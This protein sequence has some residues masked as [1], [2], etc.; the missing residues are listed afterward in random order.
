V[1]S[2][3]ECTKILGLEGMGTSLNC[4][5]SMPALYHVG[6]VRADSKIEKLTQLRQSLRVDKRS[7]ALISDNYID[8]VFPQLR[9]ELF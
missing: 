3:S 9:I 8:R 1:G 5:K 6:I 7:L 2:H 4:L